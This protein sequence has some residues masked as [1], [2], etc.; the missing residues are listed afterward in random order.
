MNKEYLVVFRISHGAIPL[1]T[2]KG[3]FTTY[4]S[5]PERM[6]LLKMTVL[7]IQPEDNLGTA[8]SMKIDYFEELSGPPENVTSF[9]YTKEEIQSLLKLSKEETPPQ[10]P[11]DQ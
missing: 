3:G 6:E 10:T 2:V 5:N 7:Q 4:K 8:T 11:G 1:E 9:E